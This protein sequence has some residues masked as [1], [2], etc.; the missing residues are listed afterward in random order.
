MKNL[1]VNLS[2]KSARELHSRRGGDMSIFKGFA[3]I[4]T[5]TDDHYAD[6]HEV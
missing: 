4:S 5:A 2:S 1:A 3:R 6:R